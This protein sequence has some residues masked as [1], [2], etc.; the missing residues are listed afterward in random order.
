MARSLR[1]LDWLNFFVANFQTGFGP[2]ISVYLTG[3]GWTQGAIGAALSAGT[4]AGMVSQVPGGILVDAVRSK[5]A[6]AAA[7]IVAIMASALAIALWPALLPIALAEILHAFASSVLGPAIAALSL[8]LVGHGGLGE[9]LGRNTR[10]LAIGNA[11]A[12][13]LMG[14]FGYYV[15]ERAVFLL[16]AAL[17]IPALAAIEMIGNE[18]LARVKIHPSA[19]SASKPE[20]S[21]WSWQFLRDR[22]LLAYAACASL[23]QLAN[24]AMLPIAA[25]MIT[26]R[27]GSEASL[28]IAACIVA[29]QAVTAA[30]SPWAG[31][32]AE[33]WGR[34]PILLLG[35]AALPIRGVLFAG[36]ADP[37]LMV[38]I[39]LLDG[40]SA[41]ALGVLTPLIV[42]DIT[43]H[44]GGYTTALGVV[45]LAI[46]GGATLSTVA[47]GFVADHFGGEATF[48]GLAAIGLCATLLVGTVMPETRSNPVSAAG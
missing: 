32:A 31:R 17:G 30:I 33:G 9:R 40:L 45:G 8:A 2:F 41:A 47:A 27:A 15:G 22:R 29:P 14:T 36:I 4:V 18:D 7:A 13:G 46:G 10:Y 44:T 5:R 21:G 23:F 25:G 28:V 26:K 3:V 43:R 37:Y 34:R 42:A 39:Q 11:F 19:A 12:A 24:A 35:F 38:L 16:T 1:G 48:L 6:A 20:N